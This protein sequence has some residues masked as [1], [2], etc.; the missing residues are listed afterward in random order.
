MFLPLQQHSP[1]PN[2]KPHHISHTLALS[3]YIYLS[4][5]LDWQGENISCSKKARKKIFP[6]SQLIP[7]KRES[8]YVTSKYSTWPH[9]QFFSLLHPKKIHLSSGWSSS[10]CP[11]PTSFYSFLPIYLSIRL[12][13]PFR[14]VMSSYNFFIGTNGLRHQMLNTPK[15][16]LTRRGLG[17][18]SKQ[19][20][21]LLLFLKQCFLTLITAAKICL[22]FIGYL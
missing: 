12:H 22:H 8:C 18:L 5:K 19:S 21:L 15:L 4:K 11:L 3:K 2:W 1:H 7:L 20:V 10:S 9:F 16:S 13:L 14:P 6:A 17:I